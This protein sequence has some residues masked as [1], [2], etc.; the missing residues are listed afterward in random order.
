[1][2]GH[3]QIGAGSNKDLNATS[4]SRADASA[5]CALGHALCVKKLEL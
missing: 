3:C 5:T 1:M 4:D 2:S